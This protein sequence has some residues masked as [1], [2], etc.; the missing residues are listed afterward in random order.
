MVA[1]SVLAALS[2]S[3]LAAAHPHPHGSEVRSAP[4]PG[5]WYQDEEHPVHALFRRQG[6]RQDSPD[7]GSPG[8]HAFF[9]LFLLESLTAPCPIN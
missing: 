9:R 2:V 1:I 4:L 5:R 3:A 8:T 7:V 6:K